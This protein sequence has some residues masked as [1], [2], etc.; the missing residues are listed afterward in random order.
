MGEQKGP[1]AGYSIVPASE[2]DRDP[3]GVYRRALQDGPVTI[4]DAEGRPS[5]TVVFPRNIGV[6]PAE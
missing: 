6:P 1:D 5:M 3:E 4:L 2:F